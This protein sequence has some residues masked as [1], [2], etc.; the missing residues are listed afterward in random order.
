MRT[1]RHIFLLFGVVTIIILGNVQASAA[2]KTPFT[3][4]L[5]FD[6]GPVPG[7]TDR[8]L[9][10]LKKYDVK[11]TFF[12]EGAHIA[13][14]EALIQREWLEG[15]HIGNH[16]I[17]HELN[18]MAE[19]RPNKDVLLSKYYATEAAINAALGS[20]L[21]AEYN[22]AEPIKPF[23]WPGGAVTAFPLSNVIT[24]NWNVTTGDDVPGGITP[25]QAM[26][27]ILYG[28]PPN[29]YY[30]VFAWG[31]GAVVLLHDESMT[32]LAAL[33]VIIENLQANGVTFGTL[34]RPGDQPGT[35]PIRIGD[36][37]P[38]SHKPGNCGAE[39]DKY[40]LLHKF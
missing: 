14:N 5:G 35:M 36:V 23:R 3:I 15:H 32:T 6:D 10:I 24:Y 31:D 26:Y 12:I 39:F 21:S 19:N 2:Q 25:H 34:P 1:I 22:A 17:S 11:A 7:Q 16:L 40:P 13:G 8:I 20:K 28:Y 9:D 27:N 18:V 33:P 37:P 29:H 4:Y 38:C 30:G